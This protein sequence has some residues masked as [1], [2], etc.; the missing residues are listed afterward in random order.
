[1]FN[2]ALRR[3]FIVTIHLISHHL[4]RS[5]V[6]LLATPTLL[7]LGCLVLLHCIIPVVGGQYVVLVQAGL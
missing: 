3:P 7:Q 2:G 1:M 6:D 4:L 5:H